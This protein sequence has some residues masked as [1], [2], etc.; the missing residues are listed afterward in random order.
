MWE[1]ILYAI[2]AATLM[3]SATAAVEAGDIHSKSEQLVETAVIHVS[4]PQVKDQG[5]YVRVEL[6]EQTSFLLQTGKPVIP[7][8][9]KTFVF[10][11][12]TRVL[13]VNVNQETETYV[14]PKMI[15]PS[16]KPVILS[17]ENM[18][19]EDEVVPDETI[20]SSNDPYPADAYRIKMGA[21]LQ[22]NEHVMF[23]TVHCYAQYRPLD[24]TIEVPREINIEVSYH[25]PKKS[26][27][28]ANEYDLLII[29]DEKFVS[30]LQPLV[31]HKNSHGIKTFIKT[32]QDIYGEYEGRDQ[33]EQIKYCI[34]DAIETYGIQYVLLAGGRIG[35]TFDWFIPERRSNNNAD[36]ESGYSSDLYYADVYKVNQ[37][38][39]FVFE[40]W[41]SNGN[42]VFAEANGSDLIDIIDY[43]PDV[44][45]GRLPIRYTWEAEVV[46]DKI[47]TYENTANP[48]W[49]NHAV[50][51][52]G[53]TFPPS[54]GGGLA[55]RGVYEGEIVADV[56]AGYLLDAG[57]IVDKLYTSLGKFDDYKDVVNAFNE[58]IGFAYLGG[59]GNPGVWGN[60]WPDAETE[61]EFSIGFTVFDIWKYAN[62][63]QLPIVVVGGCHN[64][65]FNITM[66]NLLR[67]GLKK[68]GESYPHDGCSWMVLEEAGA[69][70]SMGY[71]GY[72]YG[73]INWGCT[74]GL[75][76]W[77]EP[78]FFHAYVVQ[79]K[80]RLG[81]VHSQA[82]IDYIN[83]VGGVNVDGGEI[84]R[85]TIESWALIGDP[86]L[87][88]GG[89]GGVLGDENNRENNDDTLLH[90][91][92]T[93][94]TWNVGTTWIYRL[95]KIDFTLNEIQG[96][97]IDFHLNSGVLK[98]EVTDVTSH[99]Y[100]VRVSTDDLDVSV[101]VN[102]DLLEENPVEPFD[103]LPDSIMVAASVSNAS[104]TGD[105]VFN[106]ETM[107]VESMNLML[108]FD[109]IENLDEFGVEL[110]LPAFLTGFLKMVKI[111]VNVNIQVRFDEPFVILD[112]PLEVGKSWATSSANVTATISGSIDS[113]WLRIAYFLN[114]IANMLGRDLIPPEFAQYLPVV[115]LAQVLEDWGI[116]TVYNIMIPGL[117]DPLYHD[118]HLFHVDAQQ[119]V[120]V[121]AGTFDTYYLPMIRG[122]GEIYYSPDAGNVVKVQGNF[123]DI[124]PIVENINL[125]LINFEQ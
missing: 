54:R 17:V 97:Y 24:N 125:E 9:T 113:I 60:F 36:M 95:S 122:I 106:R 25:P 31:D 90:G 68:Y 89:Y 12:G 53:D 115:D 22:D 55:E 21:G 82:I 37:Y 102:V 88:M 56:V 87:K 33:P 119:T 40:D 98:L 94:P 19:V 43:Y 57:F 96:R 34:K 72:G 69:I 7:V 114:K 3:L 59:H 28:T 78:R 52:S 80:E 71:T 2:V 100:Q 50:M 51:V 62:G 18:G 65:Q 118:L 26:F 104:L 61:E 44:Y 79:G 13:D 117:W 16:P 29:T 10:P 116:P 110:N 14:L 30:Y 103:I 105:I 109:L 120:T 93:A 70:A 107:G 111:P 74:H 86:S 4:D 101:D 41:D 83:I 8:V 81:E 15:E 5:Q 47:I 45:V 42:G 67:Y 35:Q 23:L 108:Q 64:A 85:K 11:A 92:V 27:F 76:G 39:Q 99:Y 112:F 66:Q 63:Y 84:D 121:E 58:G 49:F 32:T 48:S 46:V 77:I 20:Y 73:Y 124:L 6:S 1:K 75:G 38:G 123:G 91:S